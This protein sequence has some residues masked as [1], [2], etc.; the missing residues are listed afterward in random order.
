MNL[1]EPSTTKIAHESYRGLRTDDSGN[2]CV[3]QPKSGAP[4]QYFLTSVGD[5]TGDYNLIGNYAAEA[6][7]FKF[8]TTLRYDIH[9]VLISIADNAAFISG[10]YGAL[11]AALTNG[12]T[13]FATVGGGATRVPLM[14]GVA[15]KKNRDWL[16]LT[17][18]TQMTNFDSTAQ[19]LTVEFNIPDTYGTPLVLEPGDSFIISLHDDFTG[20]QAHTFGLR[21]IKYYT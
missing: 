13:M 19:V 14:S 5:G 3:T 21:G 2:L 10:V 4:F 8:T 17:A 6:T 11:A 18:G 20:L 1:A 15:V 12:V 7:E 16:G 9:S